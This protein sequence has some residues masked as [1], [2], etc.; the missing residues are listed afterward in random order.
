MTRGT[1]WSD[2]WKEFLPAF[3]AYFLPAF[4]ALSTGFVDAVGDAVTNGTHL[5]HATHVDALFAALVGALG[6]GW[7][8]IQYK[9]TTTRGVH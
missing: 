7:K 1:S 6:A 4:F 8:T 5:D 9:F 3:L 2:A